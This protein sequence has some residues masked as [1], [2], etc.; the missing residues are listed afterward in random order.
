MNLQQLTGKLTTRGWIGI[1]GA[2]AATVAFLFVLMQLASAPSYTTIQAGVNPSQISKMTSALTTAGISYQLQDNGTAIGVQSDQVSQA[3]VALA[4][5][6]AGSGA[7]SL[8]QLESQVGS[9]LGANESQ[10]NTQTEAELEAQLEGAIDQIQGVSSALVQIVIPDQTAQLFANTSTAATASVLLDDS[11]TFD[12]GSAKG[13]ADLVAGAVPGLSSSRVTIT[14]QTGALLW[15]SSVGGGAG[16]L[17]AAQSAELAYDA[18]MEARADAAINSILGPGKG[19]VQVSATLNAN[20]QSSSSITYHGKPIVIGTNNSLE[21]LKSNGG[22][23]TGTGAVTGAI[24]VSGTGTNNY[25]KTTTNDTI[26][27]D[28]TV[29]QSTIAPGQVVQQNIDVTLS[30][31]IPAADQTA[32]E[33]TYIQN[34]VAAA[35]GYNAKRHDSIYTSFLKFAALPLA[36]PAS[37]TGGMSTMI[38]YAKYALVG[39]GALLFLFFVSRML[40]KRENEGFIGTPTWVRELDAPRPLAAVEAEQIDQP[41]RIMQLRAPINVAKQQVEDLVERDPDRVANQVR[42]WMSED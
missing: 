41:Q 16:G 23:T 11:G 21:T 3:Q 26:G 33:K 36:T 34:A 29:T 31:A 35:V 30:T 13:I 32:A 4:G 37:A 10:I 2:V 28:K 22:S 42:A 40:K 18:E 39:L 27:I 12:A 5:T 6:G 8:L 24:G 14:D 9:S 15:P 38:G 17:P 19:Q 7:P 20:T 1:G 25:K